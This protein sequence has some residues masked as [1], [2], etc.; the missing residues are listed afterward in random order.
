M[1]QMDKFQINELGESMIIKNIRS[2]LK[3]HLTFFIAVIC[4]CFVSMISLYYGYFRFLESRITTEMYGRQNTVFSVEFDSPVRFSELSAKISESSKKTTGKANAVFLLLNDEQKIISFERGQNLIVSFGRNFT[5][6]SEI[7]LSSS[8]KLKTGADIGE[9]IKL[10]GRN[11]KIV[12]TRNEFC[13]YNEIPFSSIQEDDE[14]VSVYFQFAG[15]PSERQAEK[16]SDYLTEQFGE[17]S[18]NVTAPKKSS[19]ISGFVNSQ[20]LITALIILIISIIN[21]I[22][23]CRYM[24][25]KRKYGSAIMRICGCTK[26]RLTLSLLAEFLIYITFALLAAFCAFKCIVLPLAFENYIYGI[27][28]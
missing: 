26:N 11:F 17:F 27:W 15:I 18:A 23:I 10:L 6:D 13:D 22:Y 5:K 3:S 19:D 7:V 24:L 16:I 25:D 21:L 2:F 28:N 12:G 20:K 9:S 1:A 4:L 8:T 14:I